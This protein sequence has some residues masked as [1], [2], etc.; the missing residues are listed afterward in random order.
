MKYLLKLKMYLNDPNVSTD[1]YY[2]FNVLNNVL[3]S[4]YYYIYDEYTSGT[5]LFM[6]PITK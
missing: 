5:L 3:T 4:L 1:I 2:V 6:M